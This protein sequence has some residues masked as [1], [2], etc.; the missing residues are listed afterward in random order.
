MKINVFYL[1]FI[2]VLFYINFIVLVFLVFFFKFSFFL[3]L[4]THLNR[5][6]FSLVLETLVSLSPSFSSIV[7]TGADIFLLC[8]WDYLWVNPST[9][10]WCKAVLYP[11]CRRH[12]NPF[13]FG[14]FPH[15]VR[16]LEGALLCF[17]MSSLDLMPSI[18]T[19]IHNSTWTPLT[20]QGSSMKANNFMT[21]S[22]SR[23]THEVYLESQR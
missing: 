2:I 22:R 8:S 9:T 7:G 1:F 6:R 11:L 23:I 21:D 13:F 5:S 16:S 12:S 20:F 14:V 15:F 19:Q 3:K 10:G 17:H 4:V 18:K